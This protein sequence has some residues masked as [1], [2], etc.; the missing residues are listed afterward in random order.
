M[1]KKRQW[2]QPSLAIGVLWIG[3]IGAM[4]AGNAE[5]GAALFRA[6]GACHS[7]Q[8]DH[9]MTGPSLAGLWGRKAGGLASFE[10]YSPA[11]RSSGIVWDEKSLDAWIRSP[12]GLVPDN[13]MTFPGIADE[14]QRADLVAFLKQASEGGRQTTTAGAEAAGLQDLKTLGVDRQVQ[15]IRYCHDTYHVTTGDGRTLDFWERNLRFKTDASSV[16][17]LAGKPVIMP[18]GMMGDRASIIFAAPEEI[19]HA[20]SHQC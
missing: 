8:R 18:A 4:A 19:G 1:R 17:P 16:G 6:C 3:T 9:N 2:V 12:Q 14:R 7:L 20:I 10:R 13:R 15:G 11:L 5:R